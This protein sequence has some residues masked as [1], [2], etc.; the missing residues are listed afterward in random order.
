MSGRRLRS[1]LRIGRGWFGFRALQDGVVEEGDD[2]RGQGEAGD[3][4][5]EEGGLGGGLRWK[6]SGDSPLTLEEQVLCGENCVV[7]GGEASGRPGEAMAFELGHGCAELFGGKQAAQLGVA[8]EQGAADGEELFGGGHVASGGDGELGGGEVEVEAGARGLLHPGARPPG[9]DLRLVRPGRGV[10]SG[11]ETG[12]A[13]DAH[14]RLV[15]R[16]DVL[17][18][19]VCQG[20][21]DLFDEGEHGGF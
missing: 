7:G 3:D 16:T 17:G 10:A 9:G 4:L 13:V 1:S 5:F 12:V 15:R 8:R 6:R 18:R 19:E 2:G 20:V 11:V 21:V 14:H